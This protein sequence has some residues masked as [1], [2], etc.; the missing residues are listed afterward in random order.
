M[1]GLG[2]THAFETSFLTRLFATSPPLWVQIIR[3]SKVN[4]FQSD[5]LMFPFDVSGHKILFVMIGAHNIRDYTKRGFREV[6]LV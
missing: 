1:V 4:I 2:I 6:V 3:R 5:I